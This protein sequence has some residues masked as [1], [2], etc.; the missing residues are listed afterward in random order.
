M[1][2]QRSDSTRR[3]THSDVHRSHNTNLHSHAGKGTIID[4][5]HQTNT[6]AHTYTAGIFTVPS[7][8]RH[9]HNSTC[10]KGINQTKARPEFQSSSAQQRLSKICTSRGQPQVK[11]K[12]NIARATEHIPARQRKTMRRYKKDR[13]VGKTQY[14]IMTKHEPN[15]LRMAPPTATHLSISF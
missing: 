14:D 9:S 15:I 2:A 8:C 1:A 5:I 7:V 13:N 3:W 12:E 6:F 10:A 4:T 11:S